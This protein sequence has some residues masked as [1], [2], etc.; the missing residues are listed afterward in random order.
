MRNAL[1]GLPRVGTPRTLPETPV[2][3]CLPPPTLGEHTDEIAA[4]Y[5][6]D[7]AALRAAGAVR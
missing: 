2:E 5:G 7:A 3:F 4:R 6:F 1:G